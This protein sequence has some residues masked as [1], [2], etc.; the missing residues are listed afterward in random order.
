MQYEGLTFLYGFPISLIYPTEEITSHNSEH[1]SYMPLLLEARH[2]FRRVVGR[3]EACTWL[4]TWDT[5]LEIFLVQ[6]A[7]PLVVLGRI[8]LRPM[9][10][11]TGGPLGALQVAHEA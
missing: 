3:R 2:V 6:R 10:R 9:R 8:R 1:D 7:T 4:Y 11:L 5:I